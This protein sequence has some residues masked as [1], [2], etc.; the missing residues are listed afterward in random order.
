MTLDE[1]IRDRSY[2]FGRLLAILEKIESDANGKDEDRET[3]AIRTQ[4][5]YCQRPFTA[6]S[7]IMTGLKVGYYPRLSS[8]AKVYYEKLIG[9][10]IEKLSVLPRNE[11]DKQLTET[12]LMGYYLQKNS[13]YTKKN[14]NEK[15]RE[16]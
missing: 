3:N 15:I 7:Q 5:F 14:I 2:L 10:I 8:K 12:Y 4:A 16:E 11:L 6:F 13:L 1:D 9:E